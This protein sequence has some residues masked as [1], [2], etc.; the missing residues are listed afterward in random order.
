VDVVV[1]DALVDAVVVEAA[2]CCAVICWD[3]EEIPDIWELSSSE[4][5]GIP[6]LK[7]P[8]Y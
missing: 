4:T 1:V 5:H 7:A 3:Q 8:F 6:F 2:F